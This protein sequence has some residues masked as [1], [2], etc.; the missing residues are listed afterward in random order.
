MARMQQKSI[1]KADYKHVLL[2]LFNAEVGNVIDIVVRK[3]CVGRVIINILRK[4]RPTLEG[5]RT[6]KEKEALK[7]EHYEV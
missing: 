1:S 3:T 2:V 5:M 4:S 7:L 6:K